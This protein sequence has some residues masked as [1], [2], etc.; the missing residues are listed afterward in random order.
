MGKGCSLIPNLR[1]GETHWKQSK[2]NGRKMTEGINRMQPLLFR[3]RKSI[4]C[5]KKV[6]G[7]SSPQSL[8]NTV[9]LNNCIIHLGL[10]GCT[11]RDLRG[12]MLF[13]RLIVR[14]KNVLFIQRDKLRADRATTHGISDHFKSSVQ[15]QQ[16]DCNWFKAQPM[17]VNKLNSIL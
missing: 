5:L 16:N 3:M 7:T 1:D 17:G 12:T 2:K 6:L 4:F 15:G 13:W 14:A 9:W 11:E 8:L 10:R